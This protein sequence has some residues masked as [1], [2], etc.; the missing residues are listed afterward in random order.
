MHY[1]VQHNLE[2]NT[3]VD[4]CND[5]STLETV[6]METKL[7]SLRLIAAGSFRWRNKIVCLARS[8]W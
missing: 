3:N 5:K 7:L 2:R 4:F 1:L 8:Q 6:T